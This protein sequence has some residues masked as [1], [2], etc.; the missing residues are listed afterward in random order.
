MNNLSK[1]VTTLTFTPIVS[2]ALFISALRAPAHCSSKQLKNMLTSTQ[3]T[4]AS[5][6]HLS[7]RFRLVKVSRRLQS[8]IMVEF[9][10][11]SVATIDFTIGCDF[12]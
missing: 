5:S 11:S 6:R 7:D 8:I 4:W 3:I 10:V 2:G 12:E 9:D 1:K